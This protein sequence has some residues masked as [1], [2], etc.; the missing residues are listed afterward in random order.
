MYIKVDVIF[1]TG[2]IRWTLQKTWCHRMN[3]CKYKL[4]SIFILVQCSKTPHMAGLIANNSLPVMPS[5]R[6]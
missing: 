6:G 1:V 5:L 3:K 4:R 2:W